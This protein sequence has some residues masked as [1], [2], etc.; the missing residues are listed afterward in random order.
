MDAGT[1]ESRTRAPERLERTFFVSPREGSGGLL[2]GSGSGKN[3]QF[4]R[5]RVATSYKAS[6]PRLSGWSFGLDNFFVETVE[7]P[8]DPQHIE[9]FA[10]AT[11]FST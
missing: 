8:L 11:G 3:A 9:S 2:Y 4:S 1:V 6:W 7:F 10:T 5:Q